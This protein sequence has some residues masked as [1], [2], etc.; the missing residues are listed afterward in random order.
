MMPPPR[1]VM[2][3]RAEMVQAGEPP[4]SAGELEIKATVTMT[5]AIK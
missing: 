4:I 5:A 1:P 2:A 3:M